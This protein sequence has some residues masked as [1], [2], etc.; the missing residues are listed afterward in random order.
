MLIDSNTFYDDQLQG[1]YIYAGL[2]IPLIIYFFFA[3]FAV[4]KTELIVNK[5]SKNNEGTLEL[6]NSKTDLIEIALAIISVIAIINSIPDLLS[7]QVNSI[8]YHDQK[9]VEF[10]TTAAKNHLYRNIFMLAAG[11]FLLLNTRNFAKWIV[12]RGEQDD[13][14]DENEER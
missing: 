14:Q 11:I 2:S 1:W 4:F 9:E 10:W 3:Y 7:Q 13:K 8:Y 5:I 6:R 12:N